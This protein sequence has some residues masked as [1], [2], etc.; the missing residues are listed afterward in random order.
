MQA[1]EL[2]EDLE[3][4]KITKKNVTVISLD[5][6]A[7]YPSITFNMVAKAINFFS[8]DLKKEQKETIEDCLRMM[9]FGMGNTLPNFA[10]KYYE[11]GR[12]NNINE[13]G[14]TIGGYESA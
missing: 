7:M 8:K 12:S 14:L 5:I 6:E 2:K 11:Y 9:K 4:L 3:S 10:G 1:S 13:R